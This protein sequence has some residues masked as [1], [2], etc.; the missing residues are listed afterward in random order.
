MNSNMTEAE[1]LAERSAK[2][3]W[4]S[5]VLVLLTLQLIIGFVAI[6]LATGDQSV[7][8][9]PNYHQA[10][11]NWDQT[12]IAR[13]AAKRNGYTLDLNVSDV[14][15]GRGM[16]AIELQVRD[17][18]QQNVDKL[19]VSGH[20]Y[21]HALASDVIPIEFRAIGDG[22]Y[23]V[24]APMGRKGLWQ[25]ELAIDGGVELMAMSEAV[26]AS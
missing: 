24:L 22:R 4:V 23:L 9:V 14:A 8:V 25:I 5:L 13:S 10:A 20:I 18:G 2:R 16:R 11:L 15:D 12:K 19:Q 3:F 1:I 17:A 26:E 7:A 6:R 21:H